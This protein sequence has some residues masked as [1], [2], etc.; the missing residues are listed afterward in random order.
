MPGRVHELD[1]LRAVSAIAVVLIHVT[2][3]PMAALPVDAPSFLA[4]SL[5]NQ[6]SRFSIPAFVLITGVVLFHTYGPQRADGGAQAAFDTRR[7]LYRRFQAIGVP[8]LVWTALYLLFRAP[9]EGSWAQLPATFVLATFQGTAMYQLYYIVLVFQFYL[10]FPLVRGLGRS[11]AL[12]WI[13]AGALLLQGVLMWDTFY[14]LFTNQVTN[15]WLVGLLRFRD[16]L[17]PWWIGYFA[18]GVW[19]AANLRRV[20]TA[21]RRLLWPLTGLAAAL[22]AWMMVEYMGLMANGASVG[23]AASGFRPTAYLYSLVASFALLGFGGWVTEQD[24]PVSRLLLAL[25]NHSFGIFL[26]HPLV[27]EVLLRLLRPLSLSPA[28]YLL[29]VSAAVLTGSYW[30]SRAIAALPFGHWIVGRT[31]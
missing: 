7:Y 23:F 26:V 20:L 13:V 11:R 17:F 31:R 16:R 4:T 24:N 30:L 29:L 3:A 10:L 8:Y 9:I 25:G 5:I 28:P 2:A 27:L 21:C 1:V 19:T 6:W 14:G 15:P 22:L 12:G 18:V